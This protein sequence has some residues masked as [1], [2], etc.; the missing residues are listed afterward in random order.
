MRRRDKQGATRR[1]GRGWFSKM[2]HDDQG[3]GYKEQSVARRAGRSTTSRAWCD[4]QGVT[5]R[6][7]RDATSRAWRD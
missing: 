2:Q 4:E 5:Q 3:A 1:A 6:A 7:G